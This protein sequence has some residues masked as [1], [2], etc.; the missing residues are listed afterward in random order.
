MLNLIE[1]LQV[2]YL[3]N[4]VEQSHRKVKGKMH[5]CL[6]WKSDEGAKATLAGIEL[7]SMIKNGSSTTLMVYLF[8]MNLRA[9]S[10]I[11]SE[12]QYV[13]TSA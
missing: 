8:G 10:L 13:C 2:K 3:N 11:A 6:G 4:L 12:N 7:W 5:Q 1:V 9:C